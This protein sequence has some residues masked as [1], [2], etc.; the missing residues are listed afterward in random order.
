MQTTRDGHRNSL[1]LLR[2]AAATMV[3]YSHQFSL[4]GKSE[5]LFLGLNTYG[6][7]GVTMFFLLSG[8]L[9]QRSW[10]SDP[11]LIRFF[12]RRGLRIFP[13]LMVVVLVSVFL[14][15][16]LVSTHMPRDYFSAGQT[17]Q[18]LLTVVLSNSW[19][20]PGVFLANPYPGAVN[21]SLWTLPVEFFCYTSVAIVGLVPWATQNSRI[22]LS[23][24]LAV[25]A[26]PIGGILFGHR[27]APH[28]QMLATFWVGV[29]LA[30]LFSESQY[31]S[32]RRG[33]FWLCFSLCIIALSYS[34]DRAWTHVLMLCFAASLVGLAFIFDWGARLTGPLGDLSYGVYIYAFPVQQTVVYLGLGRGWS[35]E[36]HLVLSVL[37]TYGLA[38]LSWHVVEKP[39]LRIKPKQ[40]AA[41]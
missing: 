15:G 18:Y 30:A 4:T 27:F 34:S 8:V 2:L 16:P 9:V 33:L 29:A 5:P 32:H 21:G 23:L 41:A 20:L 28:F 7:A 22:M 39:A 26:V 12:T 19:Y 35:F 17:Y 37:A 14:L 31:P 40:R 3:L 13:G 1:D 38:W 25:I 6:G 10:A 36:W 11:N 24:F